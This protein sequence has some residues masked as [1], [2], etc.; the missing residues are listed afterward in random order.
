MSTGVSLPMLEAI[1]V[2]VSPVPCIT[3]KNLETEAHYFKTIKY[4]YSYSG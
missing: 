1:I 2:H 3:N 4:L